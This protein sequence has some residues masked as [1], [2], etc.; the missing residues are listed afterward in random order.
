MQWENICAQGWIWK[1]VACDGLAVIVSWTGRFNHQ[2][3][4]QIREAQS[5]GEEPAVNELAF[6]QACSADL[7]CQ[8]WREELQSGIKISWHGGQ[9][10][11]KAAV[12]RRSISRLRSW[13]KIIKCVVCRWERGYAQAVSFSKAA[14]GDRHWSCSSRWELKKK[15]E[16]S[17]DDSWDK[18][19]ILRNNCR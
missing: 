9:V 19:C 7:K 2:P 4:H 1:P 15:V 10:Y 13:S 16:D 5:D 18:T 12:Q 6:A 8:M 14:L 11:N 17:K 3:T